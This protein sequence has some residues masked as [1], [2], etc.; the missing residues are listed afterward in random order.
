M[1]YEEHAIGSLFLDIVTEIL[2]RYPELCEHPEEREESNA[3][4]S[5]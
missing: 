4:V 3:T 1:T 2:E 5:E